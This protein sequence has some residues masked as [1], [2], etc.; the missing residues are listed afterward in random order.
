MR[1]FLNEA[2]VRWSEPPP[3][4]VL[5]EQAAST[6]AE[7]VEPVPQPVADVDEPDPSPAEIEEVA[8]SLDLQVEPP[9]LDDAVCASSAETVESEQMGVINAYLRASRRCR[10]TGPSRSGAPQR[11]SPNP[12][13]AS[14]TLVPPIHRRR[15]DGRARHSLPEN[16]AKARLQAPPHRNAGTEIAR[17][18]AGQRR[19]RGVGPRDAR[20]GAVHELEAKAIESPGAS[21][22]SAA[23][24][25]FGGLSPPGRFRRPGFLGSERRSLLRPGPHAAP[26]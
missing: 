9:E 26:G 7:Y 3:A 4:L 1:R 18:L 12:C 25:M 5:P 13:L 16:D 19:L 23:D 14:E 15:H 11:R 24:L 22:R 6:L 17:Q 21:S 20:V 2:I 8:P 10:P